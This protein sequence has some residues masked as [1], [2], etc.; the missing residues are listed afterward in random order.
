ML[1]SIVNDLNSVNL[2]TLTEVPHLNEI[3][4]LG[5]WSIVSLPFG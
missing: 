3:L 1:I 4:M 2:G 5:V